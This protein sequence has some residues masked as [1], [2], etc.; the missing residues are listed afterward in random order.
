MKHLWRNSLLSDTT[1]T[2]ECAAHPPGSL[3]VRCGFKISAVEKENELK[4]AHPASQIGC[5]L[6]KTPVYIE[7]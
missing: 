1:S 6:F 5:L 3:L 4:F 2:V 7:K